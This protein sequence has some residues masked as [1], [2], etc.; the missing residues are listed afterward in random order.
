MNS[1]VQRI[2]TPFS[3]ISQRLKWTCILAGIIGLM[4]L[5]A[6]VETSYTQSRVVSASV[7]AKTQAL[8]VDRYSS[9]RFILALKHLDGRKQDY[10]TSFAEYTAIS[11]GETIQVNVSDQSLGY[12]KPLLDTLQIYFMVCLSLLA[13]F[14]IVK[15]IIGYIEDK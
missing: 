4:V 11:V 10:Y 5:C 6:S 15:A 12:P 14:A 1:L 9:P 7:M 2:S 8:V 13:A 3:Q